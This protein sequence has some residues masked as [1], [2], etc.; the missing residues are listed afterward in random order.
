MGGS[1]Y[2]KLDILKI[3]Q[4]QSKSLQTVFKLKFGKSIDKYK[5]DI[6]FDMR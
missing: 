1:F 5:G 2:N 6:Q 4:E 3:L